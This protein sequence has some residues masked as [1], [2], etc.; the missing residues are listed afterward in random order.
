MLDQ[1]V[2]NKANIP[3]QL[4][5]QWHQKFKTRTIRGTIIITRGGYAIESLKEAMDI[6]E[7]GFT[8]LKRATHHWNMP[9]MSISNHLNGKIIFKEVGPLSV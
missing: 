6:M 2:V 1:Q 4:G 9:I 8:L 7:R 3:P 5:T